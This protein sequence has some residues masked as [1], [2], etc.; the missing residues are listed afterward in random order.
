MPT[1]AKVDAVNVLAEKFEK[2]AVVVTTN[3]AGLPV[4]EMTELRRALREAGVEYRIIKNTLAFLA[5][6]QAGKPAIKDVI[7]GPTGVAFGY[8]EVT[9]PAR[10]LSTFIRANR[11]ALTIQGGE[12]DGRALSGDDVQRLA[13]L[14]S[15]DQLVATLLMRMNGPIG[16]LVNV[17]NG[18]LSGL[19]R[20]L[21]G[22][23]DNMEE[24]QA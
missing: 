21:Q 23:I 17:L 16:G 2:S 18:P 20:V 15:R 4:G 8:G 6:D 10:A 11:S 9:E 13:E 1:Q 14:P 12:L 24:Q 22:R 3:Y 7:D 5:A 19:A